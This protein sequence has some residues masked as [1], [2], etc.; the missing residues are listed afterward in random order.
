MQLQVLQIPLGGKGKR[1]NEGAGAHSVAPRSRPWTHL[2]RGTGAALTHPPGAT[3]PGLTE[4]RAEVWEGG[5]QGPGLPSRRPHTSRRGERRV[6]CGLPWGPRPCPA[7]GTPT[8]AE[9]R[10]WTPPRQETP[11][12]LPRRRDTAPLER[13]EHPVFRANRRRL[14]ARWTGQKQG[15]M[16][17]SLRPPRTL[18]VSEFTW[19][20][21]PLPSDTA[22]DPY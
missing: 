2:H 13:Q 15:Q 12:L 16:E 1:G 7:T 9:P 3:R 14:V 18:P 6:R 22:L 5:R 17:L 11:D 21:A 20:T 4:T 10:A 8:L 19:S